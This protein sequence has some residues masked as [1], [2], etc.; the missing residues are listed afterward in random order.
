MRIDKIAIAIRPRENWEAVDLGLRMVQ[1]WGRAIYAPWVLVTGCFAAALFFLCWQFDLLWLYVVLFWWLK[2]L[3]G[4]IPLYVLSR[5]VFGEQLSTLQILQAVP[6]LLLISPLWH[7]LIFRFSWMRCVD[8]PVVILEG[9]KGSARRERLRL[10]RR[11]TAG[12]TTLIT[13]LGLLLQLHLHFFILLLIVF[14]IPENMHVEWNHVVFP[15][16][17]DI[18]LVFKL[19]TAG[20]FTLSIIL[21]EPFYVAAGFSLYLNRRTLL[22]GWDIELAFHRIV[23]RLQLRGMISKVATWLLCVT[24]GLY[25]TLATATTAYAASTA[26][27]GA[28]AKARTESILQTEEF[29]RKKTIEYYK[30]IQEEKAEQQRNNSENPFFKLLRKISVF[31]ATV[32]KSVLL[33]LLFIVVIWLAI[34]HQRWLNWIRGI[35]PAPLF[36]P[37]K[38]LFGLDIRPESLPDNIGAYALNLLQQGKLREALSILYRGALSRLATRD[39]VQLK[40]SFTEGDC[41]REVKRLVNRNKSDYFANLTHAWQTVAYANRSPDTTLAI[42]LCSEFALHFEAAK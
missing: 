1:H 5:T 18:P 11:T 10:L 39:A 25:L 38:Q 20:A 22:E 40:E 32:F 13:L 6:R 12:T 41:L 29:N 33:I 26:P 24:I 34:N 2:P 8:L 9:L 37:P 15:F 7:L 21:L 23:E 14:F 30:Y 36:I 28:E 17:A 4:R 16:Q 19:I 27:T 35:R 42:K 31:I 3:Y